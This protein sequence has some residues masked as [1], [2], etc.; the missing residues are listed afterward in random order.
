MN[1]QKKLY[2]LSADENYNARL[3]LL[4]VKFRLHS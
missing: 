1:V 3:G 4:T 2:I